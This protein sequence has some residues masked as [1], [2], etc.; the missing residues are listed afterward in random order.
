MKKLL[1]ILSVT[2]LIVTVF[3][4]CSGKQTENAEPTTVNIEDV[5][6]KSG[7]VKAGTYTNET[8][9]F[10]IYLP[11]GYNV[12][13]MGDLVLDPDNLDIPDYDYFIASNA[14]SV[15]V[16]ISKSESKSKNKSEKKYSIGNFE[17]SVTEKKEKK[18]STTTFSASHKD[19]TVVIEFSGFTYEESIKFIEKNFKTL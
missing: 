1:I 10:K 11:K 9:G 15:S 13:T 8:L 14:N 19:K 16:T 4:A 7:E 5:E 6:I 3:A 2:V 17:Y 18:V 12:Q